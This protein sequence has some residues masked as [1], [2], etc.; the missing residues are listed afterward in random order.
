M[1][2]YL[3]FL[4]ILLFLMLA[5][6]TSFYGQG[7][8]SA[9]LNGIVKN[10]QGEALPAANIIAVHEPSGIQYG[11]STRIDGRFN[12]PNLR[13]GGPYTVKASFVGYEG[14]SQ[15]DVYLNLGQNFRIEFTLKDESVELGEVVV[16]AEQDN[17]L[18]A[19]RTGAA[20]N[21]NIQELEQLPTISRSIKEALF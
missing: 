19:D 16:S 6:A 8:T 11:A 17:D 13:I 14:Q 1:N 3:R 20:T 9:S 12:L 5:L 4:F 2:N 7:V 18:N 21:I 10:T 15:G